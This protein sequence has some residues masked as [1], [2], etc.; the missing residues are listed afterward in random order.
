MIC[1][2]IDPFPLRHLRVDDCGRFAGIMQIVFPDAFGRRCCGGLNSVGY[3][4][5][6]SGRG[7][8]RNNATNVVE[9]RKF[10]TVAA[11]T[12]EVSLIWS[13]VWFKQM[14]I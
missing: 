11:R 2:L 13:T 3:D 1:Y 14:K 8:P 7:V 5:G 10:E 4:C 6:L 12:H 9:G